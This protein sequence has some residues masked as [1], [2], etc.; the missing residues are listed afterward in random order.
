M[1]RFTVMLILLA[2]CL[3]VVPICGA[4]ADMLIPVGQAVGLHIGDDSMV[5][6]G[7]D[8]I[9]GVNAQKAGLQVGDQIVCINGEAVACAD[10]ITKALERKDGM[11]EICYLR[12][13][14]TKCIQVQ[15]MITDDG[16][17]LGVF[18]K[19]GISGVGTITWYD[20]ETGEFGALGHGVNNGD[21]KL[22]Q[23]GK[24]GLY[25]TTIV[26]VVKGRA[27]EPGQIFGSL[28][29]KTPIGSINKNVQQGIF[30]TVSTGWDGEAFPVAESKEIRTGPAIIRSNVSGEE[31]REYSV[32]IL[33]I[34]PNSKNG[35]RNMLIKIT[36][37]ELLQ[38]TGGIV[39]GMSGSPIIQDGKL[40][41]AVTHV[42]VNDP[43][44]GYG[45]FIENMLD[46]AG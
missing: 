7:F 28:R 38:I 30:G 27:G 46:A 26:S 2:V 39:Q 32:E 8:S 21:G 33:K 43:T 19:Q 17:R 35:G 1:K 45:I 44:R 11:A 36:D 4:A 10:D 5:I 16:P 13:G 25:R 42:L 31:V 14:K 41:G 24:G 20:P 40:V 15:P 9:I 6:A 37:P 22:V 34:Y 3:W 18:L 23:V 29:D 12:N